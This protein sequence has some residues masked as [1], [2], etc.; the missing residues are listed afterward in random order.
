MR[1]NGRHILYAGAGADEFARDAG[2][3]P[4]DPSELITERSRL[5]LAG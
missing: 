2:F 5:L 3:A 4:L 1:E